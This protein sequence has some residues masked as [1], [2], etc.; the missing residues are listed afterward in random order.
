[1]GN[2]EHVRI[3]AA[4]AK[5]QSDQNDPFAKTMDFIFEQI[6]RAT[7]NGLYSV[8]WELHGIVDSAKGDLELYADRL[9]DLGYDVVLDLNQ[10][11]LKIN[12]ENAS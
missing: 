7:K 3:S 8:T 1:M 10:R 5:K 2:P 6:H 11:C 4:M 12:W 9:I